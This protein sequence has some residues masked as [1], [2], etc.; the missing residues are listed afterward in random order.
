MSGFLW[1]FFA[2]AAVNAPAA[3]YSVDGKQYIVVAAGGNA[4]MISSAATSSSPSR[5]ID[6]NPA[7]ENQPQQTPGF[8]HNKCRSA[9]RRC[10]TKFLLALPR[11][12][13]DSPDARYLLDTNGE[14]S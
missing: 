1:S 13:T 4:P 10:S 11:L 12:G 7:K 3:S 14:R 2:G 8:L 5:S 6:S 9:S